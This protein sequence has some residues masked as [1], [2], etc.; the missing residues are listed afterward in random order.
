MYPPLT[1]VDF[2]DASDHHAFLCYSRRA[3][4]LASLGGIPPGVDLTLADWPD[5]WRLI[6]EEPDVFRGWL[7]A[8]WLELE[9]RVIDLLEAYVANLASQILAQAIKVARGRLQAV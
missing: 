3:R 9:D 2:D 5:L 7:L 1:R 6:R 8:D 4:P